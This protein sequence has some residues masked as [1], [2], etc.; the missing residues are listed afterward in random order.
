MHRRPSWHTFCWRLCNKCVIE[1]KSIKINIS[2][3]FCFEI[4]CWENPSERRNGEKTTYITIAKLKIC[5][6]VQTLEKYVNFYI[7]TNYSTFSIFTNEPAIKQA[8]RCSP[9]KFCI[10]VKNVFYDCSE[11]A[12]FSVTTTEMT[13]PWE[14]LGV[15]GLA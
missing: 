6:H 3:Y 5:A 7:I 15:A 13:K 1:A 12:F 2:T 10:I 4:F 14:T 8:P 11:K 9:P